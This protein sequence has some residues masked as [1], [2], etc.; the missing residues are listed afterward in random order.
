LQ[1]AIFKQYSDKINAIQTEWFSAIKTNQ[2][3]LK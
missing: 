1:T 3:I 2:Q